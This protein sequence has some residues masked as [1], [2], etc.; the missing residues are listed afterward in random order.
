MAAVIN[1]VFCQYKGKQ[2]PIS[3][4]YIELI[5]LIGTF[6]VSFIKPTETPIWYINIHMPIIIMQINANR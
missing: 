2:D 6:I 4:Q 1:P 3:R 5:K